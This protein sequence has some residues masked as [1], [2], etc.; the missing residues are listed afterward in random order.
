MTLFILSTISVILAAY[1]R[2]LGAQLMAYAYWESC[3]LQLKTVTGRDMLR[4]PL[5]NR[6]FLKVLIMK[7][8][9]SSWA[10]I[11]F[12]LKSTRP[13]Y[14]SRCQSDLKTIF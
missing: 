13:P 1:S 8:R 2:N 12:L 5:L 6:F 4:G 10:A 3:E 14:L 7:E 9:T 11:T